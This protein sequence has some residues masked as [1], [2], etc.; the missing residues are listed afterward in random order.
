MLKTHCFF[1][2]PNSIMSV[3]GRLSFL[4]Y[5]DPR[6]HKQGDLSEEQPS[7][8]DEL[9]STELWGLGGWSVEDLVIRK[10]ESSSCN[11]I[12]EICLCVTESVTLSSGRFLQ[13]SLS[14]LEG[15]VS[16]SQTN[17]SE[18]LPH[19]IWTS[20]RFGCSLR[21]S[22][23]SFFVPSLRATEAEWLQIHRLLRPESRHPPF[24]PPFACCLDC[25]L[26]TLTFDS[27]ESSELPSYGSKSYNHN[28]RTHF[29]SWSAMCIFNT[30]GW[31]RGACIP[32]N[33]SHAF[34]QA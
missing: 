27:S 32:K 14:L 30:N 31:M 13:A 9:P 21:Q 19:F 3:P 26:E 1:L 7:M 34:L 2:C 12:S 22:L 28:K 15:R 11:S 10:P 23:L 20:R 33:N 5:R 17:R 24:P 8:W 18:S 29:N 4:L 6:L 25:L 16:S